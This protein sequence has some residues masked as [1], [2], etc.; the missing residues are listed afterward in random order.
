MLKPFSGLQNISCRL[1]RHNGAVDDRVVTFVRIKIE[2]YVVEKSTDTLLSSLFS[3]NCR[4]SPEDQ[5]WL[6]VPASEVL[7]DF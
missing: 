2:L 7:K 3:K 5:H 6:S 1:T 4:W